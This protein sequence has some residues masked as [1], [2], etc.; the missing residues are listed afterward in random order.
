M[1]RSERFALDHRLRPV[2]GLFAKAGTETARQEYGF[3][4]GSLS[5]R[6]RLKYTVAGTG[7]PWPRQWI[8]PGSPIASISSVTALAVIGTGY[9][10]LTTG[11]CFAHLGHDVICADIDIDKVAR[12]E[13]GESPIVEER[14]EEL[15][16]SFC[17]T[18]RGRFSCRYMR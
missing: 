14:V 18:I 11:A 7:L 5:G 9:V 10:G 3:H 2:F 1:S 6:S 8:G 4:R 17:R 13:R 16:V 12:L 15:R